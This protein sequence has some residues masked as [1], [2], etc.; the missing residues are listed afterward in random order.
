MA[1]SLILPVAEADI[2]EVFEHHLDHSDQTANAFVDAVIDAVRRLER[3][4]Q[5]GAPRSDLGAEFR[6]VPIRR[7]RVN[8][9]YLVTTGEPDDLVT[10]LRVLRQER[11]VDRDDL[12]GP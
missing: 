11:D 6:M 12:L 3:F 5:S 10:V 1:R 8:V 2:H 7:F 9:F 4:P